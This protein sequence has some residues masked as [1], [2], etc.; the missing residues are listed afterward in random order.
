MFPKPKRIKNKKILQQKNGWCEY[1]G[2]AGYTETH[3]IHS[4]G[5]GGGDAEDNL[6]ELCWLCHRKAHNAEISK[7]KLKRIV[8]RRKYANR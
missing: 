3:H 1:C 5:A 2:K 7:D 6:V 4:K 8:E